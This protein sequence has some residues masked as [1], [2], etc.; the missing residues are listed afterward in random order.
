MGRRKRR[1]KNFDWDS[2]D[3][4]TMSDSEVANKSGYCRASVAKKRRSMGLRR[5]PAIASRAGGIQWERMPWQHFTDAYIAKRLKVHKQTV[6]KRRSST[7]QC[8][9]GA[10]A[11]QDVHSDLLLK[12]NDTDALRARLEELTSGVVE[13]DFMGWKWCNE[14]KK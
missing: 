14:R 3:W 1:N 8:P 4:D 5:R 6:G 10:L 12:W 13:P 2:V 9:P 11:Y 7:T